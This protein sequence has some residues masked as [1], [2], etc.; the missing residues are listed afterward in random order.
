MSRRG[1]AHG[2]GSIP[3]AK[4]GPGAGGRHR[5][6]R[7]FGCPGREARAAANP[8]PGRPCRQYRS[9]ARRGD[10]EAHRQ[11]C[12][13]FAG[14]RACERP[15][16]RA[17]ATPRRRRR[18]TGARRRACAGSCV[19]R[20]R[21]HELQGQAEEPE[22][23]RSAAIGLSPHR[24][25][26]G[27][28]DREARGPQG[29]ARV[30]GPRALRHGACD[31]CAACGAWHQA[32]GLRHRRI[33]FDRRRG[34]TPEAARARRLLPYRAAG[35]PRL[36]RACREY[37]DRFDRD[38]ARDRDQARRAVPP[39]RDPGQQLSGPGHRGGDRAGAYFL[40]TRA[41]LPEA[42]V[43]ALTKAVFDNLAELAAAEPAARA[44]RLESAPRGLPVPLHKGAAKYFRQ[45]GVRF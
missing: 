16:F 23:D 2:P 28:T 15:E 22:R 17:R 44:I 12:R 31:A 45:K 1:A 11:S 32:H 35:G 24:G 19:R 43:F 26:K 25:R 21:K 18:R 29:Q 27:R 33:S 9:C 40:A 7:A 37:R 14:K 3:S 5:A 10:G 8:H 4:I 6:C 20:H 41:D 39:R 42:R 34:R 13:R 38:T 36:A 30:G